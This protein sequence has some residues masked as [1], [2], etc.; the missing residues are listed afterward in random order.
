LA[1][2]G[3]NRRQDIVGWTHRIMGGVFGSSH[4][5][6]ES[7]AVIPGSPD[8]SQV[9]ESGERDEVWV[10]VKRTINGATHRYIEMFEGYFRGPVRE[11]YATEALWE[12]AMKTAQGDAF[13]VDCGIT[14]EGS[15]TAT[16]TGL[17][18]LEGQT[19]K[20]LADGKVHSDEV[21]AS[22]SITLDYTASKVQVGLA[23]PWSFEGLKL[24]FGT[25][26]GS[27]VN[28][29]KSI[30]AVGLA[31][32]DAGVFSYGLVTYDEEEG[33]V[34]KDLTEI[35]FL[36]DG[37]DLDEAIP[38]FTGEVIR[39]LEGATRR[40]VRIYMEG[41]DPLPFTCLAMIP[42]MMAQER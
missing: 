3:Y 29:I 26:S 21:V 24:P 42:Q 14:Y 34:V 41:D 6:V 22:G 28:K 17:S 10:M 5:V 37:L 7:I 36:R 18:H 20:V 39:N 2:L 38:L 1:V 31:L 13:Y 9:V 35:A 25:Q 4:P 11:D 19:V 40:D 8:S 15:A 27:G 16:I 33:R 32:H 30:P 23:V 12:A